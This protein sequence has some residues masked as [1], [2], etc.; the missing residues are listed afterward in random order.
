M[1]VGDKV[2]YFTPYKTENGIVKS[3]PDFEFAFVVY[4][5]A[6]EWDNYQ[7]Y[8]GARTA[9]HDLREGWVD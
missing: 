8:T 3:M 1:K 7:N 4:N 6:G 9:K 5:C 2:H